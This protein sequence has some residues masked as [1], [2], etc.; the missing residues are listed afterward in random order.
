MSWIFRVSSHS[1]EAMS[2]IKTE[3]EISQG[4]VRP[5]YLQLNETS[6][7][8]AALFTL[9]ESLIGFALKLD[10]FN[11]PVCALVMKIEFYLLFAPLLHLVGC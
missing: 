3:D 8:A 11:I 7:I 1:A 9:E 10:F 4:L 2:A 5:L 6:L